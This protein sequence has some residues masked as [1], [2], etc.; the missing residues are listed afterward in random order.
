[1]RNRLALCVLL[2]LLV[3]TLVAPVA[4]AAPPPVA[5]R[6]VSLGVIS[7]VKTFSIAA[8][9]RSDA[10]YYFSSVSFSGM[11]ADLE[12]WVQDPTLVND[13]VSLFDIRRP[14]Y[15]ASGETCTAQ[16][17]VQPVDGVFGRF[18]FKYCIG[19]QP[20]ACAAIRGRVAQA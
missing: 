7:G 8:T 13:C 2:G 20:E 19:G 15:L 5:M 11:G 10:P 17:R 9:N 12:G 3:A 1:M 14:A 6:D 18:E 16:F 4:Q